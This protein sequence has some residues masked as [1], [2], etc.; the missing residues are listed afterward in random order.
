M[1]CTISP[2]KIQHG[3]NFFSQ[4]ATR[5][6]PITHTMSTWKGFRYSKH[7]RFSPNQTWTRHP[8]LITHNPSTWN[9]T[10]IGFSAESRHCFPALVLTCR[11]QTG[12]NLLNLR[13]SCGS[14]SS[15]W[16]E[17]AHYIQYLIHCKRWQCPYPKCVWAVYFFSKWFLSHDP[18]PLTKWLLH[19]EVFDNSKTINEAVIDIRDK[20]HEN[21]HL[22]VIRLCQG[23][24]S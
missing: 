19:H 16:K 20:W 13:L 7:A 22:T 14:Y 9:G 24:S 2:A 17:I 1:T 18:S 8:E 21:Y 3:R 6:G 11:W 4:T 23:L 12:R 10:L 5:L 15:W